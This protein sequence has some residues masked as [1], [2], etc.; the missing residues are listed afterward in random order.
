MWRTL[1][2]CLLQYRY[3]RADRLAAELDKFFEYRADFE[4]GPDFAESPESERVKTPWYQYAVLQLL[5]HDP[6]LRRLPPRVAEQRA[7][8][9]PVG[10]GLWRIVTLAEARGEKVN[11]RTEEDREAY[12]EAGWS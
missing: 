7:W 11:I 12:A 3:G 8:M 4:R 10:A 6:E 2:A 9:M 5:Q 1:H